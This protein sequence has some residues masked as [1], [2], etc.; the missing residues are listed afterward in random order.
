MST[1]MTNDQ[2]T[3]AQELQPPARPVPTDAEVTS[4]TKEG[5]R[6]LGIGI[7]AVVLIAVDTVAM[8][9]EG[10]SL[11][12]ISAPDMDDKLSQARANLALA[13]A[14]LTLAQANSKLAK[15]TLERDLKAGAG[16]GTSY[17]QIDQDQATVQTTEAQVA[18]SQASIKVNEAAVQRYSDLVGFQK[19]TAPFPGVITVRNVDA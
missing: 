4:R 13:K 15:I 17:Q 2:I 10:Q 9:K 7:L 5:R 3:R 1:S 11:A 12:E 19:I 16:Q 14:Q 18:S 6:I 8:V